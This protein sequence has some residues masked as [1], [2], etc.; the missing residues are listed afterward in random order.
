MAAASKLPLPSAPLTAAR[1]QQA[2]EQACRHVNA[3]R[4]AEAPK[5][6]A[7]GA[8]A[9]AATAARWSLRRASESDLREWRK[10]GASPL[11]NGFRPPRV[12]GGNSG[13]TLLHGILASSSSADGDGG[14]SAADQADR[15]A[16]AT[17]YMA[18]S[19]WEGRVLYLDRI[20]AGTS[21]SSRQAPDLALRRTLA[22]VAVD[23]ECARFVWQE[24]WGDAAGAG[25]SPP[26][27]TS[28]RMVA[29]PEHLK[30]WLT[31]HWDR[32]SMEAFL[33]DNRK[34]ASGAEVCAA[35][36]STRAAVK[37]ALEA[38]QDPADGSPRRSARLRLA[39]SPEDVGIVGRL[40]QGLADFEKE[41]DA[42]R[43]TA[44]HYRMD[45]GFNA[46]GKDPPLFYC[47]L[48]DDAVAE[49]SGGQPPYTF[50]MALINVQESL[51]GGLFVYLE[52]LFI[53]EPYRG[54]GGG[55]L[56]MAALARVS[57][58]LGC[59]KMVWQALDWNT[60]ALAFY[61]KLGAKV[62]AG[63]ETLRYTGTALQEF[64]NGEDVEQPS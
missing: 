63:L 2:I 29:A 4:Q 39:E 23:L 16:Y 41:P 7:V 44:E 27:Q 19:T 1:V 15:T 37:A 57:V 25:P 64:A 60:P 49:K 11:R 56:A 8:D 43:V 59:S 33:G 61:G 50:G 55:S 46:V 24:Q 26:P 20:V 10:G 30:G 5:P 58:S 34:A 54:M 6:G 14:G 52:D 38:L 17:F 31:L 53:E 12:Q 45:G 21:A 28:S 3:G 51:E 13:E 9:D 48:M 42:V 32:S 47:L 18:Y 36:L 40:V 22:R 62:Q 35:G